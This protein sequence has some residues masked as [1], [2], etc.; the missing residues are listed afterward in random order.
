MST[1]ETTKSAVS[2]IKP[3]TAAQK[4]LPFSYEMKPVK[5]R[6]KLQLFVDYGVNPGPWLAVGVQ[7][8]AYAVGWLPKGKRL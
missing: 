5:N 3:K 2:I 7:S 8:T 4:P 1:L 6:H